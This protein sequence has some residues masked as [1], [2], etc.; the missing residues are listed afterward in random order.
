MSRTSEHKTKVKRS[1]TSKRKQG[2]S[3]LRLHHIHGYRGAD[4]RN[5]V[6]FINDDNEL[7]FSAAAAGVVMNIS[8]GQ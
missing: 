1:T 7:V 8:S 2:I 6:Q 4:S 5:N 3:D